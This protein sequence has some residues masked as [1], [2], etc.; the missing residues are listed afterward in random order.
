[1]IQRIQS[2]YLL[3]AAALMFSFLFLPFA[4]FVTPDGMLRF[5][6]ASLSPIAG[7]FVIVRVGFYMGGIYP[8]GFDSGIG[9]HNDISV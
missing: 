1:M 8:Y 9:G 6:A 4:Q 2:V 7:I 3:V 5:D